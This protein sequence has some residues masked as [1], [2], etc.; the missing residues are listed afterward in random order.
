M[1]RHDDQS[2]DPL[3]KDA[4]WEVPASDYVPSGVAPEHS[5]LD[6]PDH[7]SSAWK[8][9]VD[10]LKD[11]VEESDER[12]AEIRQQ[13][14]EFNKRIR[15]SGE[16]QRRQQDRAAEARAKAAAPAPASPAAAGS[17]TRSLLRVFGR[18]VA[19]RG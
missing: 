9:T 6:R 14:E 13:A 16:E 7:L 1:P 11:Q 12:R 18:R 19:L 17:A 2:E 3:T 5:A 15:E 8:A 4:Y 10:S